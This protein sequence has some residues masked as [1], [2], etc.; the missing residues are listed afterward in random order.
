M[1][2]SV[3]KLIALALLDEAQTHDSL[4]VCM[5][6]SPSRIHRL[7][8]EHLYSQLSFCFDTDHATQVLSGTEVVPIM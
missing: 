6:Q 5:K 2:F 1:Q 7:L 4:S 3:V 8:S